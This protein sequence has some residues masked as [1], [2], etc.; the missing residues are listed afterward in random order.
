NCWSRS[1]VSWPRNSAGPAPMPDMPPKPADTP[2]FIRRQY[3]FAAHIRD[4]EHH[5][6]P[7]DVEDR[8]MAIYRE[9]FFNN[10][11]GFLSSSFPVLRSLLDD[12][13]WTDL[14]RDFFARHQCHTPL[15]LEIPREFLQYLEQEREA[16]DED[17][18][19][20]HELAHYEWLELALAVAEDPEPEAG[21]DPDG[22][23]LNGQ[24]RLSPLAWA[25]RYEYP[26][27]R[28]GPD[29]QPDAPEP[30]GVF[31]LV[32]RDPD[33][34]VHFLE[35]NPV[36]ARLFSLLRD[37]P[38]ITGRI[39]LERIASELGHARPEVVT[40]GGLEVLGQWCAWGIVSGTTVPT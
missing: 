17:P 39:A 2:A 25:F 5:P 38:G 13:D 20:L 26:V 27:H 19:F 8:R 14:A 32:Y 24:P 23:L 36:S 11:N 21:I 22:D 12:D 34:K 6:R 35:L 30:N 37:E 7:T 9:L 1:T 40:K 3:E 31:L 33:D 28:I 4:P 29:F 15:F 18:P 10:V 16:R